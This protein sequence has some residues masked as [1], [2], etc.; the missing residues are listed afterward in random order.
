MR[1]F[2]ELT[3]GV[4]SGPRCREHGGEERRVKIRGLGAFVMELVG[5]TDAAGGRM[6]TYSSRKDL[7]LKIKE[8]KQVS[9]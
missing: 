3:G 7:L 2:Q 8:E 4:W 9:L 5:G 1:D 6:I